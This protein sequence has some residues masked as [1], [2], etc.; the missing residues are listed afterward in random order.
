[1]SACPQTLDR[2]DAAAAVE[3]MRARLDG[4]NINPETLLATDYLNHFNEV[5]MLMEM[6]A[7]L[8]DVL[9]DIKAW[10]PK[11]YAEHFRDSGLSIGELAIEAYDVAPAKYRE[12][13][14]RTI[15]QME[16]VLQQGIGTIEMHIGGGNPEAIRLASHGVSR[17]LQMLNDTA[18]AIIHG[19]EKTM[20][21]AHIDDLIAQSDAG[22]GPASG[23]T[24]DDTT[25]ADWGDAAEG[26]D[27]GDIDAL[28]D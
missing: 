8:P 23:A 20:D 3:A 9:D 11:S 28:F 10:Q 17:A 24:A 7:D 5:I 12:P 14:E 4:S 27:Q 13:F 18:S 16:T 25:E 6:V 26:M 1:M 15:A 22:S 2:D 19:G 21:Q